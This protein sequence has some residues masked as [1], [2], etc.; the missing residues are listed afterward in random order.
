M[1]L[2]YFVHCCIARP[3][4]PQKETAK[5][6]VYI[7]KSQKKTPKMGQNGQKVPEMTSKYC[8]TDTK[9]PFKTIQKRIQ[10]DPNV[11]ENDPKTSRE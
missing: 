3:K 2:H 5:M 1:I 10:N 4:T 6:T 11:T 9:T 8:E 7:Q